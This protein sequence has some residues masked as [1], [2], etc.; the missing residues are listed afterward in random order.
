MDN[1]RELK[2]IVN[3]LKQMNKILQS[4]FIDKNNKKL[5]TEKNE[6]IRGNNQ[7][8]IQPDADAQ[9]KSGIQ[10]S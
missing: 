9:S 3:E 10:S 8:G 6:T 1:S 7:T 2:D 5:L 4:I